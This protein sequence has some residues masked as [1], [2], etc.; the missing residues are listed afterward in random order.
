MKGANRLYVLLVTITAA[1]AM[2]ALACNAPLRPRDATETPG[3]LGFLTLTAAANLLTPAYTET[4]D[5]GQATATLPPGVTPSPTICTYSASFVTDVTIPDGSQLAPGVAFD[6]TWRLRNNG[7]LPW[8][9]GTQLVFFS[10]EQMGGPAS[11]AVPPTGLDGVVDVSVRLTAPTAA[12]EYVGWW[13][14]NAP[15]AGNFGPHVFV[16][17]VVMPVTTTPTPT[18]TTAVTPSATPTYQPFLG[19]WLNQDQNTTNITR[20]EIRALEGALLVHMW[21]KCV[22]AD[23]DR[24]ETSTPTADAGDGVLYLSWVEDEFTETQQL[25]ILL[26]RRLQING[27]VNYVDISRA[28]LSYTHYFVKSGD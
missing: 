14:L 6:K 27:Q 8:P 3:P 19:V 23:C 25:S 15:G 21:T 10:G 5:T 9:A 4:P 1:L 18:A 2:A 17:I 22:P 16:D 12:G 13:Q 20:V 26:D 11:T 7:C 28:D 24:G